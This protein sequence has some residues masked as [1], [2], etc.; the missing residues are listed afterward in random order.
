MILSIIYSVS[1]ST[2]INHIFRLNRFIH[3]LFY[4]SFSFYSLH[5]SNSLWNLLAIYR[6][7]FN[8][9][10]S[11]DVYFNNLKHFV[12]ISIR[13]KW[14]NFI[15]GVGQRRRVDLSNLMISKRKLGLNFQQITN[16]IVTL[17]LVIWQKFEW[18][19]FFF[20]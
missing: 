17:Y 3:Y 13:W 14:D 15:C 18:I 20:K 10:P 4:F 2:D 9:I 7:F 6:F 5:S 12:V 19:S 1:A 8:K 11:Q 16:V